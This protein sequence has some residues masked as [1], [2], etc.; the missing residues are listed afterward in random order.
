MISHRIIHIGLGRTGE[1]TIR[2]FLSQFLGKRI[3]WL[4]TGAH[5][6]LGHA[7]TFAPGAPS[8]SFVRNP[9][10]WYISYWIGS[11]KI[12]KWRGAFR[13]FFYGREMV[14]PSMY[15]Q[16]QCLGG[17][18]IDYIGR[19]EHIVD[20]LVFILG[21]IIPDIVSEAEIRADAPRFLNWSYGTKW[22]EGVEQWMREELYTDKDMID[23]IYVQDEPIFRQFGYSF[24][25]KYYFL[26]GCGQSCHPGLIL[27]DWESEKVLSNH[28]ADWE[29]RGIYYR[30]VKSA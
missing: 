4:D 20:D 18:E 3:T 10:D 5:L 15:K 11:M 27:G 30:E 2:N 21:R 9:F 29:G 28:W 6:P 16:F 22:V 19:F 7:R 23:Q 14:S 12:H 25:E 24:E 17:F 8:F 26:G 13:D 1:A